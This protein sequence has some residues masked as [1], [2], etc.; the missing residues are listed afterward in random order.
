[1]RIPVHLWRALGSASVS[2]AE[3]AASGGTVIA[4]RQTSSNGTIVLTGMKAG[5][6]VIE[7]ISAPD[8]YVIND[9][10]QTVYLSGKEQD[11]I[12]V[13]FGND[14]M[15]SFAHHEKGCRDGCSHLRCRVSRDQ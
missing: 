5:T 6:Y 8:G 12:T 13:V 9:S 10:A 4:E 11:V 3:R 14:K 2:W 7:E 1:M 15:G